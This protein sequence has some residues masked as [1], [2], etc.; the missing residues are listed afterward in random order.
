MMV[1][2]QQALKWWRAWRSD[3]HWLQLTRKYPEL[4]NILAD[5]WRT[6]WRG[7]LWDPDMAES[8]FDRI[9]HALI[10]NAVMILDK[11][12]AAHLDGRVERQM[13]IDNDARAEALRWARAA[14]WN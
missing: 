2:I 6:G 14:S 12:R 8:F 9:P 4:H 10:D 11:I 13:E 7:E 5:A 1:H 3:R